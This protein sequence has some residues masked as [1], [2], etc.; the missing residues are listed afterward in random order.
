MKDN[1]FE[2]RPHAPGPAQAPY[3]AGPAAYPGHGVKLPLKSKFLA[4]LFSMCV[5]GTGQMYVGAV[6]RGMSIMLL[7]VLDIVAIVFFVNG[8]A[9]MG[10]LPVTLLSLLIPVLYFYNVF[11]AVH[12]TDAINR[13][14]QIGLPYPNPSAY[15]NSNESNLLLGFIGVVVFICSLS[16]FGG[17]WDG[18]FTINTAIGGAVL[19]VGGAY[20]IFKEMRGK[21]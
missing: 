19:L 9:Q 20:F 3:G 21:K 7:L 12:Q 13:A 10:V 15:P 14:I 17:R 11:D 6:A 18:L 1:F 4:T 16:A 5:P 2:M 8:P